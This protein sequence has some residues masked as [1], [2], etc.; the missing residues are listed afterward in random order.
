MTCNTFQVQIKLKD[1]N[2]NPPVF[3]SPSSVQV[4]EDAKLNST[5]FTLMV[6]DL[7]EGVNSQTTF[8]LVSQTSSGTFTVDQRTGALVLKSQLDRETVSNHTLV[9]EARDG[10]TPQRSSQQ[11]LVVEILDTNDN[12]PV[13][14]QSQYNKTVNEDVAIGTSLLRIM[15]SDR[16][17][18]LNGAVRYFIVGGVGSNDFNL[19]ISSGVLRVQKALD[20]ERI[21]SYTIF[22]QAEDSSVENRLQTN[23]TIVISLN[24]V[25][26]FVPVFDNSPYIT[27]VQEGMPDGPVPI[28]TVTAR[29]E[30]SGNNGVVTYSLRDITDF[31]NMF[32]VDPISGQVVAM[33]TLDRES[34]PVYILTIAAMDRGESDK[35]VTLNARVCVLGMNFWIFEGDFLCEIYVVF[36]RVQNVL[37]SSVK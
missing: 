33:K 31:T 25:N 26:D 19:D 28:I 29:D 3:T 23:A 36:L 9:V 4:R 11:T 32:N 22:I 21:K 24:D 15:A 16:D 13:F 14:T 20:Y 2:D 6:Q 18:G 17:I 37:L 35:H 5:V 27:F 34:L 30:D 7:D 8:R 10:G 1:V 12:P